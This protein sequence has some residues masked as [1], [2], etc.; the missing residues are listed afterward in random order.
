MSICKYHLRAER[1]GDLG[2]IETLTAIVFGPG[3]AARAAY[4]LREGVDHDTEHSF[5]ATIDDQIVGT[6]RLTKI[7]VGGVPCW[8]LG[9]L[10]VSPELK[11]KG[12]GKA[13]MEQAVS[14]ARESQKQSG[15]NAIFLV[16]DQAYYQ[17]FGFS[18]AK[19]IDL[20][21]PADHSRVL[22][23]DLSGGA[24]TLPSGRAEKAD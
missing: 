2:A 6:V 14:N 24:N 10:G 11:N 21:R 13:L 16:G 19:G 17:P 7:R 18:Q 3:M 8:L 23:C 20:P 1:P 5:V 15:M 12:L 9:P 4:A 22:I